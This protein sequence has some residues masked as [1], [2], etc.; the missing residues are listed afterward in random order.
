MTLEEAVTKGVIDNETLAYF[1]ARSYLFLISVG[2][3]PEGIR[4]RQHRDDE[5][6]HYAKDCWD[7]EVETSYGW[8]EVAG[9]ADRSCFDLS[10]HAQRTKTELVAA[11][12]LKE[13]KTVRLIKITINKRE[14]GKSFKQDAKNI[15]DYLE[16][17]N[18]D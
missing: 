13:P 3:S 2:I 7:A 6:A 1:M 5:M 14:V 16:D 4:F 9:H 15:C 8:I 12:L 10:R 18:Q 17:L 11:R